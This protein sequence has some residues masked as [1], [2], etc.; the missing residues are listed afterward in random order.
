MEGRVFIIDNTVY[1]VGTLAVSKD[2]RD[3]VLTLVDADGK[4]CQPDSDL[5]RDY[6]HRILLTSS[7]RRRKDRRWLKQRVD[8]HAMFMMEPWSREEFVVASFV[9]PA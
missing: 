5:F 8:E 6:K 3:D 9:Y 2:V 7:P 1:P 4:S